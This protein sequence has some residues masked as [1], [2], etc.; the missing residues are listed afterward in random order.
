[1]TAAAVKE[2][3]D[4]RPL[5]LARLSQPVWSYLQGGDGGENQRAF[6]AARLTPRPLCDVRGGHTRL[7]LFGQALD[8]PILLAPVAYQ[9]LFHTGGETASAMAAAAQGGQFIVS[10]LASQRFETIV[11]AGRDGG[12]CEPWFQLY[13]QGD[14]ART[15]DVLQHA[16]AAGCS[17][18]VLTV[19]APIKLA[20]FTLPPDVG[21]V[22]LGP[23]AATPPVAPGYSAVFNGWMEQAPTWSDL[24][25]LRSQT[26]L[27]LLVKGILHPDDA[28]HAVAGGCDGIIVSGHGGRVFAGAPASLDTLPGIAQRIGGRVPVLLDSGIR[29]GRDVFVALACGATAVL[30]GRPYVW[31]LA[32]H[33]P[34]GVAQ[35]IRLLR[36]DLEMTMALAGCATLSA[37]GQAA[38]ADRH[39]DLLR[40]QA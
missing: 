35:V 11:Q 18:V 31:G 25:W 19:D 12:G 14:R 27:P 17:A 28:E 21:A 6:A 26:A 20:T 32:A 13:W 22:N 24:D 4:F 3:R 34:M 36:D 40:D 2:A 30:I 8:H 5:A 33:G 38:L 1:M 10:T 23:S 37:I 7:T 16:T 39:Q 29:S 9:R 15:L